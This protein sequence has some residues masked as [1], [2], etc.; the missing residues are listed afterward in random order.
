MKVL[1][2]IFCSVQDVTTL[3]FDVL[4]SSSCSRSTVLRR[5]L[6]DRFHFYRRD[7][8]LFGR[9][10]ALET[11]CSCQVVSVVSAD[12]DAELRCRVA[13]VEVLVNVH[14]DETLSHFS[15]FVRFFLLMVLN[16]LDLVSSVTCIYVSPVVTPVFSRAES[17]YFEVSF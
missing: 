9:A 10:L 7:H 11:M 13:L 6:L 14:L 16:L 15:V 3:S 5:S 12:F 8:V 2:F 1:V 17:T 4:A